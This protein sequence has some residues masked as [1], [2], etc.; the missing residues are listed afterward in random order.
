LPS[1]ASGRIL[2]SVALSY[3]LSKVGKKLWTRERARLPRDEVEDLLEAAAPGEVVTIDLRGVDVFD[4]SFAAEF[5]GRL[6]QRLP[7]EHPGRFLVIENVGPWTGP[8]LE[9]TLTGLDLAAIARNVHGQYRL[10][11]KVTETDRATFDALLG[12]GGKSTALELANGLGI[13]LTA[14]N[15]RLSKLVRT[16]VIRRED[17][18]GRARFTYH[19]P[20]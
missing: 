2:N 14:M 18:P 9:A 20:A 12:H 17:A 7:S 19:T 16:G 13:N 4:F 1:A 8:N 15:E 5:F 3:R 11:G 10:L 6:L